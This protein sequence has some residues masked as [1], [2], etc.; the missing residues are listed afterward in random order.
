[1]KNTIHPLKA[2]GNEN[3]L[4]ILN[5]L[6]APTDHFPKQVDGDLIHDGVCSG[7]LATKLGVTPPALTA[8]MKI[9]TSVGFVEEKKLKG[10]VFY[11]RNEA[12]ITQTMSYLSEII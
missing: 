3:R 7:A 6:K 8:H 5:W 4:K 10:W 12:T 1:M 2:L 11:K 9:L